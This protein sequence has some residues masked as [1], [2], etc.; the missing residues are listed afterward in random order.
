VVLIV[1]LA[2]PAAFY[3]WSGNLNLLYEWY[4]AVTETTGPNLMGAENISFA[5]MWAKWIGPGPTAA[6]AALASTVLAVAGGIF[7][8]WWWRSAR[9]PH[10]LDV[11]YFLVLI[12]LLSPQGWDYVLVIALPAY[13]L[14]V[15]RWRALSPN[16]RIV[17]LT[18]IFLTS[19]TIFDL[20]RRALYMH[21]MQLGVVSVGAMLIAICLV[22]LRSRAL[23]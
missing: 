19:F 4:R 13:V 23:A 9:D 12:P 20:L 10:Y 3:G 2:L 14:L 1:G 15:D 5:S 6:S 11:A 22:R 17:A 7:L 18:G 8:M 16:W 21:L